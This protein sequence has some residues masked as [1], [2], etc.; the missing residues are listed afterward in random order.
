MVLSALAAL[1]VCALVL[2]LIAAASLRICRRLGLDPIEVLLWLGLLERPLAVPR[3][4]RRRLG[5]LLL[6][7]AAPRAATVRRAR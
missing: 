5:E 3:K 4:R 7:G 6:D 1:L 2:C